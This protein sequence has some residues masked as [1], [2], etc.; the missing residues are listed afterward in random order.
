MI[1]KLSKLLPNTSAKERVKLYIENKSLIS[2][3]MEPLLTRKEAAF[4][5][6]S[7]KNDS[8]IRLLER[9]S[10][11][12][13]T[14]LTAL[15]NLRASQFRTKSY[16]NDLKAYL[17][18]WETIQAAEEVGNFILHHIPSLEKRA[19]IAQK[20]SDTSYFLL[21]DIRPDKEGYLE[22]DAN[23]Y[24]ANRPPLLNVIYAARDNVIEAAK[25]AITWKAVILDAMEEKGIEIASYK[26]RV[27]ED[28][29][30]LIEHETGLD[31]YAEGAFPEPDRRFRELISKYKVYPFI[32]SIEPDSELYKVF[33]RNFSNA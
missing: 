3:G 25:D 32:A 26:K 23:A 22:I 28:H 33:Y 2:L 21:S 15:I 31:K 9:W 27:L 5:Y 29:Q 14:A 20:V 7:F 12:Q 24:R 16:L 6:D 4:L 17:F 19:E 11:F 10:Y 8:E 1:N 18:I 13:D 30:D